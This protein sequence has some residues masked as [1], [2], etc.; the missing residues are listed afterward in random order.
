MTVDPRSLSYVNVEIFADGS[1]C[2]IWHDVALNAVS[3]RYKAWIR[4][5]LF[6]LKKILPRPLFATRDFRP[7]L[8]TCQY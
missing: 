7:V 4:S 3:P 6:H 5:A 2:F 1:A 8:T